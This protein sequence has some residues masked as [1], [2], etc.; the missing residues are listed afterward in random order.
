MVHAAGG[1]EELAAHKGSGEGGSGQEDTLIT[2]WKAGPA[3]GLPT[4]VELQESKWL[5]FYGFSSECGK[6]AIM[7]TKEEEK[8]K[9]PLVEGTRRL[10]RGFRSEKRHHRWVLGQINIIYS[11]RISREVN[12]LG[13]L[14]QGRGG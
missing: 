12:F 7:R 3:Q 2:V 4:G 5:L 1:S 13:T 10:V 9:G 14:L 8:T 6:E 11:L